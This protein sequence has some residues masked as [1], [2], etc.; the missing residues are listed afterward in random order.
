M[1]STLEQV[2]K[3]Y[4]VEEERLKTSKKNCVEFAK[5]LEAYR[6]AVEVMR[7]CGA[8]LVEENALSQKQITTM[9]SLSPVERN[10]LFNNGSTRKCK[11]EVKQAKFIKQQENDEAISSRQAWNNEQVH[12]FNDETMFA[13]PRA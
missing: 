2:N 12:A 7:V 10:A 9:F 11:V 8:H 5:T 13:D 4:G 1:V 6:H 3:F